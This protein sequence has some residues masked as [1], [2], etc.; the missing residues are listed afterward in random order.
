MTTACAIV[1][2]P[3]H[4]YPDH[5]EAPSRF[6]YLG[7][8]EAK[9]YHRSLNFFDP[10]PAQRQSVTGVHS[11]RML[12]EFEAACRLGPGITDYAPTYVTPSTFA[13]AFLAAGATLECTRRILSGEAQ[14]A[15][16]I[17]R[18][19]GHHAEPEAAMG[20]CLLNNIA[21]AAR[22]ALSE[23][24]GRLLIVDFDVHHGNGTQAVFF[25]EE[26]AAFLSTQ[27]ENIYPFRTGFIEDAPQARGRIVN[28]PLPARAGDR[29]F[30]RIAEEVLTPMAERFKP[31]MMF[32]SAGFD[33][34]W[35]DPLAELGLSSAGYYQY[36]LRLVELAEQ[37]CSGKIVF[38][39][40]G[41]YNPTN[42]ASG[43]EAVLCA[44]TGTGF[45]G[46]DPSPYPEPDVEERLK[47]VRV[48]S[49]FG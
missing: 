19:P 29:V 16:A 6:M 42:V 46:K 10:Q 41:G 26:R 25:A 23:G 34:H 47:D 33:S 15:F 45:S 36:A 28:V 11:E 49:G 9:P 31:E 24:I 2:S 30:T 5:E 7:G 40:E 44:L 21:I 1:L 17:V 39:L 14:N 48:W 13:D 27:Q 32:V 35:D 8:W 18:P 38:T 43:V 37:Y 4:V 22:H 12:R 20:F 3:G